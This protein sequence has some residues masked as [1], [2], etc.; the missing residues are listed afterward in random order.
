MIKIFAALLL[1]IA[2]QSFLLFAGGNSWDGNSGFVNSSG[3]VITR[4]PASFDTYFYSGSVTKFKLR[5]FMKSSEDIS[6]KIGFKGAESGVKNIG[7]STFISQIDLADIF[8]SDIGYNKITVAFDGKILNA[9][10]LV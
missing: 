10:G 8:V 5:I 9:I 2:S 1:I 6:L 7:K 3:Y 4:V